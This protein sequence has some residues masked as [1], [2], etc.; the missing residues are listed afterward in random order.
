MITTLNYV[1]IN[2]YYYI[3]IIIIYIINIDILWNFWV[4]KIVTGVSK[5]QQQQQQIPSKFQLRL[6]GDSD[7]TTAVTIRQLWNALYLHQLHVQSSQHVQSQQQKLYFPV[8]IKSVPSPSVVSVLSTFTNSLNNNKLA[9]L[10]IQFSTLNNTI[11]STVELFTNNGF[12]KNICNNNNNNGEMKNL[13]SNVIMLKRS[14]QYP[15]LSIPSL[16]VSWS[17]LF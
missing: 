9:E 13:T 5:E 3:I 1:S 4:T 16:M 11:Q 10:M 15:V 12:D 6:I 14:K 2:I 7:L 8:S 17:D